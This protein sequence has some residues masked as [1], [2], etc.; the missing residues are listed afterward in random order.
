MKKPQFL[1][2]LGAVLLFAV[3]ALGFDTKPSGQKK[4][5]QSRALQAEGAT[6]EDLM[7][8]G[9]KNLNAQQTAVLSGLE[10]QIKIA[11]DDATKAA[12][13]KKMSA[14]WYDFGNLPVAGGLAAEVAAIE[15]ADSSWSVAGATYY[16]ALVRE[17]DLEKRKYCAEKAVNAFESAVSLAPDKPEHRVNLALVYAENPP[18]DNPMQAV[19]MLRDLE[20]KHP[21]NPAVYNALGRLAIKT[22]QWEKAIAR[23]EKAW[24]LDAKNPNTPCL[25]AKAYEGAGNAGKAAEFAQKCK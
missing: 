13:L 6:L 24:A 20:T 19:L 25:L 12:L 4:I 9:L 3:L 18:P 10:A 15:N 17:Q 5:E 1:A 7:A 23:L 8:E 22:G 2:L 16:Q 11:A 14:A 21:E